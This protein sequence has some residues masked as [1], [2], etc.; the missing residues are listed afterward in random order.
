MLE[1]GADFN[2]CCR[3]SPKFTTF[4]KRRISFQHT[5]VSN[6]HWNTSL[7]K[8]TPVSFLFFF[9]NFLFVY[10][11]LFL[12]MI[13]STTIWS[14]LLLWAVR[15]YIHIADLLQPLKIHSIHLNLH[16][17]MASTWVSAIPI[18]ING[19]VIDISLPNLVISIFQGG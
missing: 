9:I 8:S 4:I 15:V 10:F 3:N 5:Q 7:H 13:M 1:A 2:F 16:A 18:Q 14:E 6:W 19:M 12:Y 17:L 11:V